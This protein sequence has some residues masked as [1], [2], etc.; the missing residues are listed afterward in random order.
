MWPL[1]SSAVA[2]LIVNYKTYDELEAA[3]ASVTLALGPGDELVVFD[4]SSDEAAVAR[5]A[6]RHPRVRWIAERANLGFAA[7][8]N[9]AAAVTTAP[10][11]LLLNPD[12]RVEPDLLRTLSDY[13]DGHPAVGIVGPRVVNADGSVQASA[14]RFPSV[15]T[16]VAGRSTWLSR[17]FPNNWLTRQNLLARSATAAT[18]VDWV[19]GSCLATRRDVFNRLGGLDEGF[20]MY[21]EDADY[22]RRASA[23]GASCVFLPTVTVWHTSGRSAAHSP[24]PSIR[25]FHQSAYRMWRKHAPWFLRPAAPLAK[26]L[27]WLRGEAVIWRRRGKGR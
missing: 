22:A 17:R 6:A 2:V 11:L 15:L 12:T 9:R 27:L 1:S 19:A 4:Q 25:A 26:A 8:V 20:F 14:R 21:R 18:S 23:L 13:L 5:L 24:E 3:L 7:G 16:A 10:Y